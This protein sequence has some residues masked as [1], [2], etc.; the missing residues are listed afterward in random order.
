[1]KAGL[2]GTIETLEQRVERLEKVLYT[3]V[4]FQAMSVFR[5][6]ILKFRERME[7]KNAVR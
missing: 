5:E 4:N 6:E 3:L 1:M 2:E 7:E